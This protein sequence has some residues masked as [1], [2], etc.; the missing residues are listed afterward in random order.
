MSDYSYIDIA[1]TVLLVLFT[2]RGSTR[3]FVKEF[4]SL[5]APVLGVIGAFLFYKRGAEFIT[6]NYFQNIQGV[7]EILAF[8]IIFAIIFILCKMLQ[9]ILSD[10]IKGMNLTSFDKILGL[11]FGIIEGIAVVGLVIFI[12]SI[13]PIVNPDDILGN[14]LFGKLLMPFIP[15]TF[16]EGK[17]II[18]NLSACLSGSNFPG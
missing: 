17:N 7:P 2:V 16:N 4:F 12:I 9:K 10:V 14:S 5:G 15:K 1:F 11:V 13:Q 18:D 3:G 6:A 8:I